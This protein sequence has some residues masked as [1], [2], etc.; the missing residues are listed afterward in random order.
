MGGSQWAVVASAAELQGAVNWVLSW[1][2]MGRQDIP[3]SIVAFFIG[4][5]CY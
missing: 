5:A 3:E 1:Y 4:L 2:E